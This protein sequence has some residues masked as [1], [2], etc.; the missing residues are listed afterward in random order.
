MTGLRGMVGTCGQCP[1]QACTV[2]NPLQWFQHTCLYEK[3]LIHQLENPRKCNEIIEWTPMD[4]VD[5]H[6]TRFATQ[7]I[8]HSKKWGKQS[9]RSQSWARRSTCCPRCQRPLLPMSSFANFRRCQSPLR[10][11]SRVGHDPFAR[12]LPILLVQMVSAQFSTLSSCALLPEGDIDSRLRNSDGWWEVLGR[13]FQTRSV[14][15][16]LWHDRFRDLGYPPKFYRGQ[17]AGFD[18]GSTR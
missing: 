9:I 12:Q 3:I 4:S 10:L 16:R 5:L 8:F 13:L 1:L 2:A 14:M 11:A 17:D 7:H 15:G 18:S 6:R